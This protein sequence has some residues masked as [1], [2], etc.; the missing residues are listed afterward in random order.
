MLALILPALL[1][2]IAFQIVPILIGANA[3]FRRWSLFNPQKT[4][5]GF[6]N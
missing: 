1:I 5:V 2:L 3:S 4:F 6:E